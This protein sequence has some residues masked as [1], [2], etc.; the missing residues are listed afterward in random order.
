M[1]RGDKSDRF[2]LPLELKSAGVELG[3]SYPEPII[4]HKHGR[5]RALTAYAKLRKG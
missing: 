1:I 5:E 4:D 2:T 3:E